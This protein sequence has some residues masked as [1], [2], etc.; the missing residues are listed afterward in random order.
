M[1]R[2][3][4]QNSMYYTYVRTRIIIT[5][6]NRNY[7]KNCL[8]MFLPI[9]CRSTV[10]LRCL[11]IFNNKILTI[12]TKTFQWSIFHLIRM[13]ASSQRNVRQRMQTQYK[14]VYT[15]MCTLFIQVYAN[16]F[17]NCI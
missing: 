11:K 4:F 17:A 13:S 2:N 8:C 12:E 15:R 14:N 6:A 1:S 10:M 9:Y 3:R 16:I 5:F 7:L